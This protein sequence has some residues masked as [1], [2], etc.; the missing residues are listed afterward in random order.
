MIELLLFK[1]T[2]KKN[3]LN[4]KLRKT[5][6]MCKN[7]MPNIQKKRYFKIGKLKQKN[8]SAPS[9]TFISLKSRTV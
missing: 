9:S 3:V 8:Q 7:S 1:K 2:F 4:K 5:K 6:I